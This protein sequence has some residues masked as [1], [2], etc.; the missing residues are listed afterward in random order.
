MH[1]ADIAAGPLCVQVSFGFLGLL[2]LGGERDGRVEDAQQEETLVILLQTILPHL[3]HDEIPNLRQGSGSVLRQQ[4]LKAG[5]RAS[6]KWQC[7]AS[8]CSRE[9]KVYSCPLSSFYKIGLMV[10]FCLP[11]GKIRG[12]VEEDDP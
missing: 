8:W 12:D 1:L 2:E 9:D 5:E 3:A 6:R 10:R 4:V 7:L 11:S